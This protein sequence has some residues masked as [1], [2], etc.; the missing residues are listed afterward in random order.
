MKSTALTE[1]MIRDHGIILKLLI[2]DVSVYKAF[3]IIQINISL[4][5]IYRI[6]KKLLL[7]QSKI[8]TNISTITSAPHINNSDNPLKKTIIHLEKAF[9]SIVCPIKSYQYYFNVSII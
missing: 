9:P 1:T 4:S 6:Y 8:R 7:F 3:F 5:S 2:T